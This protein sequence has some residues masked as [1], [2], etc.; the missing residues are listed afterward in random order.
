[1]CKTITE[2]IIARAAKKEKVR[3]GEI[4]WAFPDIVTS[5]EIAAVQYFRDLKAMGVK[6][7]WDA[8]RLILV[9]DHRVLFDNV[10]GAELNREMRGYIKEYGVKNFFD[11]GDHGV[12]HQLP[13]EKGFIHP[14][15]LIIGADTHCTTLGALGAVSV[16]VNAEIPMVMATG[17]IWLQVPATIRIE[18]FGKLPDGVMS[19]DVIQHILA[20]VGPDRGD[21]RAFEFVGP[22]VEGMDMDARMTLCNP[23]IE[24]GGKVGIIPPDK[25]TLDYLKAR[26]Q[27]PFT[28]LSGDKD[29]EVEAHFRY[30]LSHLEPEVAVPPSPELSVPLKEVEGKP[31]DQA[32]IGSCAGGRM[33]DLRAAARILKGRKVAPGVRLIVVPASQEIYLSAIAEGLVESLIKAGGVF[34]HAACGPCFGS[35]AP[36]ASREVCIGTGT[37]NEPGRMGSHEASI[38]LASAATVAASAVKGRITDPRSLL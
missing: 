7:L 32:F 17:R 5:P 35:L 4:V 23:V 38:Y 13:V 15:Q 8:D 26:T 14:G 24:I 6:K 31:I 12:S 9:V 34:T 36:L 16:P 37:R 10:R 28:P 21:Y 29:A 20:D 33:E 3:V 18:L 2:K 1:M 27:E 22:A 19:R 11:L 30:D 25:T